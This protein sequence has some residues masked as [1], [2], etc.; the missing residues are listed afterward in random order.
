MPI[1]AS[2]SPVGLASGGRYGDALNMITDPFVSA[3]NEVW[4]NSSNL[5]IYPICDKPALWTRGRVMV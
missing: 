4:T 3:A 2:G 5:P 1:M